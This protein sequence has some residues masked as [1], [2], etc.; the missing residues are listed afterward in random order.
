MGRKLVLLCLLLCLLAAG[1]C[2]EEQLAPLPIGGPAPYAPDPDCFDADGWGYQ[3]ESI[4]VRAEEIR[5]Y[6][7]DITVVRVTVDVYK[8]QGPGAAGADELPGP[9]PGALSKL[10]GGKRNRNHPCA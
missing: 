8:R 1:A 5:R 4:T 10:A 2:A 3:D 9:Y 7:T 6:D